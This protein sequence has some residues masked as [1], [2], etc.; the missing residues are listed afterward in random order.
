[1]DVCAAPDDDAPSGFVRL[2]SSLGCSAEVIAGLGGTGEGQ[3]LMAATNAEAE[4][5]SEV[6]ADHG[7]RA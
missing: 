1:M 6:S 7:Y 2:T 3:A 4:A 5:M